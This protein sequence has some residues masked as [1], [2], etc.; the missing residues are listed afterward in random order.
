MTSKKGYWGSRSTKIAGT[1]W[2]PTTMLPILKHIVEV[3]AAEHA[4]HT[5]SEAPSCKRMEVAKAAAAETRVKG[6]RY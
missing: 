2:L 1:N 3:K 5:I 6:K 4:A